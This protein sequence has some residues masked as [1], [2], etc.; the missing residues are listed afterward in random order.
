[1]GEENLADE[2]RDRVNEAI[3]S[4]GEQL[5]RAQKR[6]VDQT[7]NLEKQFQSGRREVERQTRQRVGKLRADLIRNP[8]VQRVGAAVI[9]ARNQLETRVENV[10]GTFQ[11]ASKG[12]V[13]RLDKKLSQISKKLKDL[14]KMRRSNGAEPPGPAG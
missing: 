14:E 1:M 2:E 8:T 10:L 9:G 6:F 4:I 12:D 5:Q 11:I 7:Q 13:E 3:E